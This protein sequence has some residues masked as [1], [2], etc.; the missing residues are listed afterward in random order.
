MAT[1]VIPGYY[2]KLEIISPTKF[3]LYMWKTSTRKIINHEKKKL[4]KTTEDGKIHYAHGLVESTLRE[5]LYYQ[6]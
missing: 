1:I 2:R 3:Y 6:K 4:K 5:W